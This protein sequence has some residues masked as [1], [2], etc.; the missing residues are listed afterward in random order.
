MKQAFDANVIQMNLHFIKA[1][2]LMLEWLEYKKQKSQFKTSTF[3]LKKTTPFHFII[4][5][6][7]N[8]TF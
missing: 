2:R 1:V 5:D 3:L 6:T 8:R 4:G 7:H